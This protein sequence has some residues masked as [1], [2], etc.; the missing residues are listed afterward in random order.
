MDIRHLV[1]VIVMGVLGIMS[2]LAL[3]IILNRAFFL[4]KV[5]VSCYPT[6]DELENAL[7]AYMHLLASIGAN[8]PYIG[9]LGTVMGIMATFSSMSVDTTN[10]SGIMAGLSSALLATGMG[11]MVAIPSVFAYNVLLRSV[12]N[13]IVRWKVAYGKEN[14]AA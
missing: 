1:D 5:D 10:V 13:K 6:L 8:A 11:L 9:L 2:V 14:S 4:K 12:K 3:A 7:T